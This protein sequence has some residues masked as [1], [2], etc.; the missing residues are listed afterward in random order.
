MAFIPE[1]ILRSLFQHDSL[2]KVKGGTEMALENKIAFDLMVGLKPIVIDGEAFPV[3]KTHV[4]NGEQQM[5]A[6]A[7]T[8]E[9]PFKLLKGT[10]IKILLKGHKL[11]AGNHRIRIDILTKAAGE[12]KFEVVETA[13]GV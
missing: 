9:K 13:H 8:A 3:E 4:D 1:F 5:A 10:P 7:V 12:L 11:T 2:K 6:S